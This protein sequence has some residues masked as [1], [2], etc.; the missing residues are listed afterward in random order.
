MKTHI[1][2]GGDDLALSVAET[3]RGRPILF[4]HGYSQSRMCWR[5][6]FDADLADEFRLV[7]FDS[8]GHGAS[9]KPRDAYGDSRLWA[10]DVRAIITDLDLDD[11]V[12]VGW[13]YG[14]LTV[15]DYVEHYGTD[16]LAGINLIG[17]IASIGTD[18]A[19]DRL[20]SGYIEL[21][22]GFVSTDVEESV[23]TM[24]RFVDLCVYDDL[25]PEDRYYM[26][27]YNVAVPPHVRDSLRARTEAHESELEDL[28]VPV[29]LTHGQSDAVIL[30]KA[31]EEYAEL[32]DDVAVSRYPETGHSPFWE[33]ADRFNRELSAFAEEC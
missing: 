13:S 14:G 27:G 22:S 28:D 30:P 6:Q 12:L 18:E 21:V 11:V 2:R 31:S 24:E 17:A 7:S 25:S 3:G 10:D 29:L 19:T 32:I 16:R 23:R 8:R 20:G 4:V 15:L 1:V 5:K 26:L 33:R 9:E